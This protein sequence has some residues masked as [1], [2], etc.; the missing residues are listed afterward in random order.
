M[1][2]LNH[3]TAPLQARIERAPRGLQD[4]ICIYYTRLDARRLRNLVEGRHWILAKDIGNK[5]WLE[6]F[7]LVVL[8]HTAASLSQH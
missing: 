4:N 2:I 7:E 6:P 1:V 5:L 3:W 8:N